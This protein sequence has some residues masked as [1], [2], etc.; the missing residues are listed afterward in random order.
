M[1]PSL[2]DRTQQLSFGGNF[3]V[4]HGFRFALIGHFYSPLSMPGDYGRHREPGA[5]LP[6]RLYRERHAEQ[7]SARHH[8]W[9]VQTPVRG[10]WA[11]QRRS[12][13]TTPHKATSQLR[14][15]RRSSPMA[16]SPQRSCNKSALSPRY[17]SQAPANQLQFPWVRALD[18]KLSWIHHF[19]DR[20]TVEPSVG[21]FNLANFSNFN[22]PPD[23]I[24]GWLNQGSSSINS[25]G[26]SS[27]SAQQ[28]RVG[29]GTGVFGMG[30]PRVLEFGMHMNF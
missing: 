6:D 23:V 20:F 28:F 12:S 25:V 13:T 19:N 2:L 1:G 30:A 3:D 4:A 18:L 7:S 11:E 27:A 14:P 17:L 26:A 9:R 16:C 24:S 10:N 22:Q 29:A 5:D 15:A 21:F 8:Q